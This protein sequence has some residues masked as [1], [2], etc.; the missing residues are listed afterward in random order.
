MT[1]EQWAGLSL[2]VG[3]GLYAAVSLWRASRKVDEVEHWDWDS[4]E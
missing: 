4:D 2:L 1:F 3:T